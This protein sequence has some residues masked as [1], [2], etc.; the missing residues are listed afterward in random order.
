MS[1]FARF[2][3]LQLYFRFHLFFACNFQQT[4][5]SALDCVLYNSHEKHKDTNIS[6]TTALQAQQWQEAAEA[7]QL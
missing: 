7:G 4:G 1:L 5:V 2:V 3:L 6:E